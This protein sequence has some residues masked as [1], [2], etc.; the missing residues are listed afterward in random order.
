MSYHLSDFT[1]YNGE[2]LDDNHNV[3]VWSKKDGYFFTQYGKA[4]KLGYLITGM[5]K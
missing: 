4:I 3:L 5:E 1:N 2:I